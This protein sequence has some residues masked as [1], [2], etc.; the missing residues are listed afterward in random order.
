MART[1]KVQTVHDKKVKQLAEN[2]EK[3]GYDVK[4]DIPNY[5]QPSTIGGYRPDVIAVKGNSKTV[6]E[7]ETPDSVNTARDRGQQQAFKKW[8]SS[9]KSKHFKKVVTD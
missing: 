1:K 3:K 6:I 4:A 5:K 7:V 8:A 2:F 9:S